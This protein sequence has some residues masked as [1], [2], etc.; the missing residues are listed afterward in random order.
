M[1]IEMSQT[2][3]LDMDLDCLVSYVF[4]DEIDP[5][6]ESL[7]LNKSLSDYIT[8]LINDGE[9]NGRF[10]Q[11]NLVHTHNN[12]KQKRILFAGMG[13]KQDFNLDRAR[14]LA[15]NVAKFIRNKNFSVSGALAG[16]IELPKTIAVSDLFSAIVEGASLGLY[17]F[18]DHMRKKGDST[19]PEST[20]LLLG[21]LGGLTKKQ[22]DAVH[23]AVETANVVSES[24]KLARDLV[25]EPANLMTP[26]IL[27]ARAKLAAKDTKLDYQSLTKKQIEKLGMGAFLGV[28]KGSH[29]EPKFIILKYSG[30]PKNPDKELGLLGKGITFDSGGISIKPAA[31]MSAMK[32][33]MGGAAAVIASM[34][35]VA[36]LELK[37]N[38]TALVPATENLPGGSATKPGDLLT[39]MNGTTIEVENTDAEGR[40]V[41]A[42]ALA[43]AND[44]G[45]S[46]LIDIATLTGAIGV[47][48]GSVSMGL[49]SNDDTLANQLNESSLDT[50]EKMWRMPL[51]DEYKDQNKSTVADIKNTGGRQAGSITAAQF[52]HEFAG[53]TPWAHLDIASVFMSSKVDGIYQKGATGQPVRTLISLFTKLA[54]K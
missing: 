32:G 41:L 42:D 54:A 4:E 33:D 14:K 1:N 3:L 49:F 48:L 20:S 40:L 43:Y 34:Y 28:A 5:S 52:L 13:K 19:K 18:E 21:G 50:G 8:D 46:P 36:R 12:A 17:T 37:I 11:L 26:T 39:A 47:A 31:N 25:N 15:A 27:A 16:R 51:W 2:N 29:E 9:V 7:E 44:Q 23:K 10:G 35:G 30:D 38:I 22:Q 24:A 53:D 6:L 45:L